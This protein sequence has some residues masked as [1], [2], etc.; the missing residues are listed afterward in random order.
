MQSFPP[1]RFIWSD[2]SHTS[3]NEN[4]SNISSVGHILLSLCMQQLFIECPPSA[5]G[6]VIEEIG[7]A[8]DIEEGIQRWMIQDVCPIPDERLPPGSPMVTRQYG[9]L[10][11]HRGREQIFGQGEGDSRRHWRADTWVHSQETMFS[12]ER[13]GRVFEV[14]GPT[15]CKGLEMWGRMF[16]RPPAVYLGAWEQ[17]GDSWRKAEIWRVSYQSGK[18][19]CSMLRSLDSLL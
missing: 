17:G 15:M 4:N 1:W 11:E 9:R 6:T 3:H 10:W 12:K 19:L 7:E 8:C 14:D 2:Y 5:T 13:R 16:R 18:A